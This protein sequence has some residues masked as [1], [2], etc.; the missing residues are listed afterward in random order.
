M[1]SAQTKSRRGSRANVSS[2]ELIPPP[3][4]KVVVDNGKFASN[5]HRIGRGAL[6]RVKERWAFAIGNGNTTSVETV[7]HDCV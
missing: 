7:L 6:S 3:A 2:L 1:T 5:N 4:T